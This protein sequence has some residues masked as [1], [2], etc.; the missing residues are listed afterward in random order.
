MSNMKLTVYIVLFLLFL[1]FVLQ[2]Y[3]TLT[4]PHSLHLNL[5][6]VNLE[7]VPLPFYLMA[8]LLFLMGFL[9]GGLFHFFKT[10][11]LKKE[12]KTLQNLNRALENE[13]GTP[14]DRSAPATQIKTPPPSSTRE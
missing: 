10:H 6:L 14:K 13:R 1:V 8:I 11:A 4:T 2:N 7:S 12:I 5:G 9:L 3:A